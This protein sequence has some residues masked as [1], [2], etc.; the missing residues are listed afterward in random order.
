VTGLFD[1]EKKPTNPY[2]LSSRHHSNGWARQSLCRS[3]TTAENLRVK[4]ERT[5]FSETR[6]FPELRSPVWSSDGQRC[7]SI[8]LAPQSVWASGTPR[9][10]A[11]RR[12][13]R[14]QRHNTGG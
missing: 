9:T 5:G 7:C 14:T 1:T 10:T 4:K 13:L 6:H 3:F 8:A 11:P 2:F 12:T